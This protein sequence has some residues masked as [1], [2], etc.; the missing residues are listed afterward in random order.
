[1]PRHQQVTTCLRSGGPISKFCACEHCTLGVCSVCGAYEGSLTTDCPGAKVDFDKQQ[2]V[3]QTSLDF[4]DDRG[5]HQGDPAERRSPRFEKRPADASAPTPTGHSPQLADEKSPRIVGC[6]CGWRTPQDAD[7]SDDAFATHAA[8]TRLVPSIDWGTV[9]RMTDLAHELTQKAIAW[10]LADRV[11]E[12]HAAA[13]TR[14]EDEADA[15]L[16]E[17]ERALL[18][19]KL[20]RARIDFRLT[21]QRAQTCDDEFRQTARKLVDALEQ[22]PPTVLTVGPEGVGE[23]DAASTREK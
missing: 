4:T 14:I 20:E 10:V 2:E 11:C 23:H 21:D 22:G 15:Q 5:W 16:S 17:I 1:M 3:Y 9:D 18:L 19:G 7:N 8:L 6:T 13:L 12:D